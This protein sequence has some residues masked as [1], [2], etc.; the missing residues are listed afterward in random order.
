VVEPHRL[1]EREVRGVE[2]PVDEPLLEPLPVGDRIEQ[3][4]LSRRSSR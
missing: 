2:R 4:F 1:Q 3:A